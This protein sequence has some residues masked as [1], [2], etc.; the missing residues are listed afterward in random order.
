[1][2]PGHYI[3]GKGDHAVVARKLF[4]TA[5]PELTKTSL[6][7]ARL[8]IRAPSGQPTVLRCVEAHVP[9]EPSQTPDYPLQAG[10]SQSCGR[11]LPESLLCRVL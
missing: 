9:A 5:G 10:C 11:K 4:A 1:M 8:P 2:G 3:A 7:P 6:L